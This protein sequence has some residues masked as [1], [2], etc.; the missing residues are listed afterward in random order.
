[1]TAFFQDKGT[2]PAGAPSYVER[3]ADEE[4]LE[5]CRA[6]GLGYILAPRQTG[7]SSLVARARRQLSGEGIRSVFVD[8][9]TIGSQDVTAEQ[10]YCSLVAELVEQ[11]GLGVDPVAWWRRREHLTPVK[12]L[13]DF[14]RTEV[15]A[16]TEGRVVLFVDEIDS[17]LRLPFSTD[18]FFAALRAVHNARAMEPEL[19]RLAIVLLGVAAPSDL[20]ADPRRTPFNVGEAV[21]LGDLGPVAA[22]EVLLPGLA[23]AGEPAAVLERVFDWTG[24]HP[25]L[26]QRLCAQVAAR[27]DARP[28]AVDAV[29]RETLLGP[30]GESDETL[31]EVRRLA[32]RDRHARAW[33]RLY[34]DV[35]AGRAPEVDRTSDAQLRA[36]LAGL[37]AGR[38]GEPLRPRNRVF[39]EV[40]G[41][42]WVQA[43]LRRDPTR[44]L[45]LAALAALL[46][47]GVGS[48]VWYGYTRREARDELLQ[49]A[50]E[51]GPELALRALHR[52]R[53]DHGWS[54]EEL[55]PLLGGRDRHGLLVLF[56][57]TAPALPDGEGGAAVLTAVR[58]AHPRFTGPDST[59][60]DLVGAMVAGLDAYPG[61]DPGLA[62]EAR[63][64]KEEVVAPLR[65]RRPPRE[66]AAG[67]WAELPAGTFAMGSPEDERGRDR[68][69]G[70]Q[71]E[72]SVGRFRMLRHEVTNDEYRRLVPGHREDEGGK[73]PARGV[74]WYEAT[75]YAAWLGARLPTEAEWEYAAKSGGRGRRYPWGDEEATCERAVLGHRQACTDSDPCG[76]GRNT[77][78]EVCSKP[79]GSSVQGVCDLAGNLWEWCS[80][81]YGDYSP[82]AQRDPA[83]A[84]VG[85]H[86]VLRGGSWVN[87]A[88]VLRASDRDRFDPGVRFRGFGFRVVRPAPEP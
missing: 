53:G 30:A 31:K 40:F 72:V 41:R 78:W 49:Q 66:P 24:G 29:V 5:L 45:A 9:T 86:R 42:E 61:R 87:P 44:R 48:A 33:V 2:L 58:A 55:R 25:R 16:G 27:D 37:V 83:G 43:R 65:A 85:A 56:D 50:R 23:G 34:G 64:L 59:D 77:T 88:R 28:A 82:A 69:E 13:V 1:L 17:T 52:L 36:R 26:T 14:L 3:P 7:K 35:L 84:V 46:V 67:D 63:A 57:R 18:D 54:P 32:E 6:G 47:V 10:W 79:A 11:L 12:R 39:S 38:P 73:L 19:V 20:I 74:S 22:A 4:V 80:D 21:E 71:H 75:A 60:L 15:V 51:G 76:C 62:G 8:L 70:P 68:D 81:W